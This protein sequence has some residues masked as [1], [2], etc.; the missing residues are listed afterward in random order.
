MTYNLT[1]VESVSI[2]GIGDNWDLHELQP[3]AEAGVYTIDYEVTANTPWGI[4]VILNGD[5]GKKFGG[6]LDK[7]IYLSPS[8]IPLDDSYIGS[9]WT[10]TVDLCKGTISITK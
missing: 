6:T 7:M 2:T 1:A 3:T 4:Q 10:F 5:W 9:T 8:N